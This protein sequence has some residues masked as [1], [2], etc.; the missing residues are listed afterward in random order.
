[1]LDV[2]IPTGALLDDFEFDDWEAAEW[3]QALLEN[4]AANRRQGARSN[5]WVDADGRPVAGSSRI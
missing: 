3:Q 5:D 4:F 2:D 1:M